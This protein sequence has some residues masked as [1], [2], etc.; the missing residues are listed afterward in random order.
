MFVEMSKKREI[1]REPR[2][3]QVVLELR[4]FVAIA[5][6]IN[7]DGS[8]IALNV[9]LPD[10]LCTEQI[11]NESAELINIR[12]GAHFRFGPKSSFFRLRFTRSTLTN[13]TLSDWTSAVDK[14]SQSSLI[15]LI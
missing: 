1:R 4:Y 3:T 7:A 9:K 8:L 14:L 15:G 6:W 13:E 12:T 2:I 5:I 11:S 10:W